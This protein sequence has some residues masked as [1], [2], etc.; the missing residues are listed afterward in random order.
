MGAQTVYHIIETASVAVAVK[1]FAFARKLTNKK[2]SIRDST[3]VAS[4]IRLC[5][6]FLTMAMPED[7]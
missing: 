3:R 2:A 5:S 6:F 4:F 1:I 7:R